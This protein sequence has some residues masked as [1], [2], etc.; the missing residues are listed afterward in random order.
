MSSEADIFRGFSDRVLWGIPF[1]QSW[2]TAVNQ[3]PVKEFIGRDIFYNVPLSELYE[4]PKYFKLYYGDVDRR[5]MEMVANGQGFKLDAGD[6]IHLNFLGKQITPLYYEMKKIQKQQAHDLHMRNLRHKAI[7]AG[8]G[9]GTAYLLWNMSRN[10]EK[11]SKAI[12]DFT[13]G[14]RKSPVKDADTSE[15]DAEAYLNDRSNDMNLNGASR[16][17]FDKSLEEDEPESNGRN[18]SF[19]RGYY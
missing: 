8:L 10:N 3:T 13:K 4:I 14:W 19:G 1:R 6:L 5:L 17:L 11:F 9:L 18:A 12:D 15:A 7:S 2:G 16:K